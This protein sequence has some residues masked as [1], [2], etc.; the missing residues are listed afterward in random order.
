MFQHHEIDFDPSPGCNLG[1]DFDTLLN[2]LPLWKWKSANK[3]N[4]GSIYWSQ[5]APK[6]DTRLKYV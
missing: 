6:W 1:L 2:A 4:K 3:I 5:E